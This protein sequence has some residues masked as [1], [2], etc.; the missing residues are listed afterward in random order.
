MLDERDRKLLDILQ[1]DAGIS[2]TALADAVALS[3]SACSRRIQRLEDS[4][5]IARQIVVLDRR[6]MGVP[7]TVYALIK[8]AHHADEWIERFKRAITD[9]PEIVEAHR[10][11]GNHDYILKIVLPSVEHYDVIYKTIVRRV[12][13]FDVAAS[14]S[15]EELKSGMAIPVGYAV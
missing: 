2:V 13:L 10:L 14:I 3:V 4:G 9:I 6:K 7:T 15:M 8:T 5:H 12:E 11:T 1:G